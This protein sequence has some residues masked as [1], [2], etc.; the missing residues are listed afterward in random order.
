MP[1]VRRGPRHQPPFCAFDSRSTIGNRVL[2]RSESGEVQLE[3][4][5]FG[6]VSLKALLREKPGRVWTHWSVNSKVIIQPSDPSELFDWVSS[7]SKLF[8]TASIRSSTWPE[9]VS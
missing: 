1:A 4:I 7:T 8:T 5:D 6:K 2:D 9:T 3:G